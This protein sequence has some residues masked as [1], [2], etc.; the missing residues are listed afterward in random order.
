MTSLTASTGENVTTNVPAL[1]SAADI[2]THVLRGSVEVFLTFLPDILDLTLMIV[3]VE[4]PGDDG[5]WA[6]VTSAFDPS[7]ECPTHYFINAPGDPNSEN[8]VALSE[9]PVNLWCTTSPRGNEMCDWK[10]GRKAEEDMLADRSENLPRG[11]CKQSY[12]CAGQDFDGDGM[13]DGESLTTPAWVTSAD[14]RLIYTIPDA[15]ATSRSKDGWTFRNENN[16]RAESDHQGIAYDR[17]LRTQL[18]NGVDRPIV[19]YALFK[20]TALE[21]F[22]YVTNG[23]YSC[24]EHLAI[25]DPVECRDAAASLSLGVGPELETQHCTHNGIQLCRAKPINCGRVVLLS[26]DGS[27][28]YNFQFGSDTKSE[29]YV[30]KKKC[31]TSAGNLLGNYGVSA[32]LVLPEFASCTN[33]TSLPFWVSVDTYGLLAMGTGNKV[34]QNVKLQ[35]TDPDPIEWVGSVALATKAGKGVKF[36]GLEVNRGNKE[37][38]YCYPPNPVTDPDDEKFNH[39]G[40]CYRQ[41]PDS[42]LRT[43]GSVET[44]PGNAPQ[45]RCNKGTTMDVNYEACISGICRDFGVNALRCTGCN[46]D[47]DCGERT[48]VGTDCQPGTQVLGWISG[49]W[50]VGDILGFDGP[51]SHG[52]GAPNNGKLN[53]KY[54]GSHGNVWGGSRQEFYPCADVTTDWSSSSSSNSALPAGCEKS[55]AHSSELCPLERPQD[56]DLSSS[57]CWDGSQTKGNRKVCAFEER[58]WTH[59]GPRKY[60]CTK[61]GQYVGAWCNEQ[62]HC[63]SDTFCDFW[64]C[65]ER[66]HSKTHTFAGHPCTANYMCKS[67]KCDVFCVECKNDNDEGCDENEYCDFGVC[68]RTDVE[69]GGVCLKD[70]HCKSGMCDG[71]CVEC[72]KET[73]AGCTSSQFCDFGACKAKLTSKTATFFGHVCTST[74]QCVS[75]KCNSVCVECN[76]NH[77]GCTSNEYCDGGVCYAKKSDHTLCAYSR[78]CTSG[79]CT[80]AWGLDKYCKPTGG[81]RDLHNCKQS[82]HCASGSCTAT[83]GTDRKCKPTGG[84]ATGFNQCASSSHCKSKWCHLNQV[85]SV[86]LCNTHCGTFVVL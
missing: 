55:C 67:G 73:H 34:G 80:E 4:F 12:H 64:R 8:S 40:Q 50:R 20:V 75:G 35:W 54:H 3:A 17:T 36:E 61:P 49:A 29:S 24:A 28:A 33:K 7:L 25:S 31:C 72:R 58:E 9:F 21:D 51:S 38:V 84:W 30:M 68:Y 53:V 62:S 41:M 82:A 77:A 59:W 11:K 44:S 5:K 26:E 83:L 2:Y 23:A 18:V 52:I 57:S 13:M 56:E 16:F 6:C 10:P 76:S 78:Q 66:M 42:Y 19:S 86:F 81:F 70:K 22:V 65:K 47:E 1:I 32:K 43:P 71:V 45:L 14:Y 69:L 39:T 48:Y 74:R 37:E 46:G 79:S 15:D 60:F 27:L 63:D 85:R